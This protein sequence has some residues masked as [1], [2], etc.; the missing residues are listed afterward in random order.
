MER[1]A[2]NAH[3]PIDKTKSFK[4]KKKIAK[5]GRGSSIALTRFAGRHLMDIAKMTIGTGNMQL[6]V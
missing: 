4:P 2:K 1:T 6:A 5:G 3:D